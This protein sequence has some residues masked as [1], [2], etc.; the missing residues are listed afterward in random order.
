[1]RARAALYFVWCISNAFRCLVDDNWLHS[2]PPRVNVK[3]KRVHRISSE[4]YFRQTTIYTQNER[5]QSRRQNQIR[6]RFNFDF[7]NWLFICVCVRVDVQQKENHKT[8]KCRHSKP[9][10]FVLFGN[11][12]MGDKIGASHAC[13]LIA[14]TFDAIVKFVRYNRSTAVL[15]RKVLYAKRKMGI[16]RIEYGELLCNTSVCSVALESA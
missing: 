5:K 1:M 9:I 8:D 6:N 10:S 2:D 13:L 16:F 4:S 15:S 7:E 11:A 12:L 3:L 14:N